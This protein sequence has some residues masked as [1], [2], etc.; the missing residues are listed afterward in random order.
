MQDHLGK[1]FGLTIAF[2]IPGMVALYALS[3]FMPELRVW[4]GFADAS[5][6][7]PGFLFVTVASAGMGVFVSGIRWLVLEQWIWRRTSILFERDPDQE[8][9]Y[10]NFVR[11]H[12]EFYLFYAN[13]LC[14]IVVLFIAWVVAAWPTSQ[15]PVSL[16][17]AI[18]GVAVVGFILYRSACDALDR[19]DKK[20]RKHFGPSRSRPTPG[21]V[22]KIAS[23]S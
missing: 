7:G 10:Q 3:F 20:Q 19:F 16:L 5:P 8:A 2:V 18:A 4:F 21:P 6:T 15:T 13:T 17:S 9:L 12:Y 23:R 22:T 1:S 11:Q 14:A